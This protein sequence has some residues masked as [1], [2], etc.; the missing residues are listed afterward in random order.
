MHHAFDRVVAVRGTGS[1]TRLL[2]LRVSSLHVWIVLCWVA[3]CILLF[4]LVRARNLVL[5]HCSWYMC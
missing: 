3:L 4:R 1:I 2:C 5:L